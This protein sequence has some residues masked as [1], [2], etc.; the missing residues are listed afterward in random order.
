MGLECGTLG[1]KLVEGLVGPRS[2]LE[3]AAAGDGREGWGSSWSVK[4]PFTAVHRGVGIDKEIANVDTNPPRPEKREK[5][6]RLK[7]FQPRKRPVE[8]TRRGNRNAKKK[9]QKERTKDLTKNYNFL[10]RKEQ[11][12]ESL[13]EDFGIDSNHT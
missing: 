1:E 10:H 4:G 12:Q 9:T 11:R 3:L 6:F 7:A 5:T 2:G 8:N 13:K